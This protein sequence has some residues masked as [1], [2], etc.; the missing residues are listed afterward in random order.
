M[1]N[2]KGIA[3]HAQIARAVRALCLQAD[4]LEDIP[5]FDEW[6]A[7]RQEQ[8]EV[9]QF[10]RDYVLEGIEKLV[11][12]TAEQWGDET[13]REARNNDIT[14]LLTES[15]RTNSY[16]VADRPDL[17][18]AELRMAYRL[19]TLRV[20]DQALLAEGENSLM[21]QCYA[22][23]FRGCPNLV[24]VEVTMAHCLRLTTTRKNAIFQKGLVIPHGDPSPDQGLDAMIGLIQ[25]AYDADFSPTELRM[26][27]VTHYLTTDEDLVEE[28]A[29][30]LRNVEVL[31][32]QLATPFLNDE[33]EV[34]P[35]E[36]ES[37]ME[38]LE[39]GNLVTFLSDAHNLRV[40][41]IEMPCSENRWSSPR[42]PTIVGDNFWP[43]LT[44]LTLSKFET[45]PEELSGFL[46]RHD[47]LQVVQ[48]TQ[49]R[50][51]TGCWP[52]CFSMF[53]GKLP[54]LEEVE[55]RGHFDSPS[56]IFYWFGH[57]ESYRGNK[58]ER[59]ISQY[60]I[61]GGSACPVAPDEPEATDDEWESDAGEEGEEGERVGPAI[62]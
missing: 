5:T 61:E 10:R 35:D 31:H 21:R 26:G 20:E 36:Y 51:T 39:G 22:A 46:L 7:R 32:W 13:I 15:E 37:I 30:F 19:Y 23:F 47:K 34:D 42:L 25:A 49:V 28:A 41:E 12:L 17:T 18:E 1:E 48:L 56:G 14:R 43:A 6:N 27:S 50:L 44:S 8:A 3:G 24:A 52:A 29:A 38:D 57:P 11:P 33:L 2:I 45:S 54:D 55:L 53:A 59:K 62:G 58:F 40:L 60:I 16:S 9:D 4:H